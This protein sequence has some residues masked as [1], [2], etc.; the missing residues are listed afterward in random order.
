MAADSKDGWC[1][2]LA[3]V[4]AA[5]NRLGSHSIHGKPNLHSSNAS[6]FGLA[7]PAESNADSVG[8]L[9]TIAGSKR[10]QDA[11]NPEVQLLFFAGLAAGLGDAEDYVRLGQ[12]PLNSWSINGSMDPNIQ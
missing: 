7:H 3:N 10:P 5:V 12:P 6:Q 1:P 4:S 9:E 11:S 8:S 2:F